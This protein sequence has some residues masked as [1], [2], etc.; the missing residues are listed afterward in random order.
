M[1][2]MVRGPYTGQEMSQP[3]LSVVP[4]GLPAVAL[5]A[6]ACAAGAGGCG[7]A[8]APSFDDP[9]PEARIG[10]IAASKSGSDLPRIVENLSSDD[11]AV[12]LAAIAA[13]ER[14]TGQT[15]GYRFDDRLPAREA[16]VGRWRDAVAAA[17]AGR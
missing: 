17:K 4:V 12:R 11:A 7:T 15:L 9:T 13:L 5:W 1:L 14:R 16:A 3:C 2:P 6:C 10:A 8:V